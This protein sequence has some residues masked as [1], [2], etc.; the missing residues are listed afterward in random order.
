MA[1]H[2]PPNRLPQVLL[3]EPDPD[4]AT[5]L[6]LFLEAGGHRVD[7]VE[8][9]SS[10]GDRLNAVGYDAVVLDADRLDQP[11]AS[12][13]A[14]CALPVVVC[15]RSTEPTVHAEFLS[16]GARTVLL[17]PFPM[18]ELGAAVFVALMG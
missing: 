9:T 15:T 1:T 3:I 17:K 4:L 11:T 2:P 8:S 18:D 12:F 13:I 6:T 5:A 10:H 14:S 7:R 16:F